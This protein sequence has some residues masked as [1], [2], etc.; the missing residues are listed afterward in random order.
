MIEV[1]FS[2]I[3]SKFDVPVMQ[4]NL[5][6]LWVEVM[7]SELLGCD[8]KHTGDDW[9]AWDIEG[10]N[11]VRI[12]VKQSARAQSW[13]ISKKPPIF[14]IAAAKGHY[15]DG[16]TYVENA[17]GRRFADIYIFAWHDGQDQRQVSEWQFFVIDERQLPPSQK[18]LSLSR[19]KKLATAVSASGLRKEVQSLAGFVERTV[20]RE[21]SHNLP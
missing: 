13:G 4:N 17:T 7:I 16:T 10:P 21:H 11:N 2:N 3:R 19:V 8:W 15:P 9:A 5:R 14:S 20:L 6:G 12:E 1:I 18:T